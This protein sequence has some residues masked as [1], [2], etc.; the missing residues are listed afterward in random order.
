M[1][2]VTRGFRTL[3]LPSICVAAALLS[4]V[5]TQSE[6]APLLGNSSSYGVSVNLEL[7]TL[8]ALDADLVIASTPSVSGSAPA[9]YDLDDSVASVSGTSSLN[10][11]NFGPLDALNVDTGLVEVTADSTVTG[12]GPGTAAA[13]STVADASLDI[14]QLDLL[15]SQ[16]LISLNATEIT[17]SADISGDYNAFTTTAGSSIAGTA[18]DASNQ[19]LLTVLGAEFLLEANAA[20]NT[21]FSIDS[22]FGGPLAGFVGSIDVFLNEQIA[23]GDGVN[24]QGVEVNALRLAFNGV[25]VDIGGVSPTLLNGEVIFANSQAELNAVPEP[26]SM[27]LLSV[28]GFGAIVGRYRRRRAVSKEV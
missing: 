26:S 20:P 3:F 6:A 8:G 17:S 28:I 21:M 15:I 1:R 19:A 5:P 27:A 4:Q 2:S 9:P 7:T 10:I 14:N 12:L 18:G 25:Q 24:S 23:T 16:S 11:L 22:S 13:T